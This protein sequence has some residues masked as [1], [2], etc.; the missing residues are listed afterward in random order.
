MEDFL[1]AEPHERYPISNTG[2]SERQDF[3]SPPTPSQPLG[4]Y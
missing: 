2:V 4:N 3:V 1:G